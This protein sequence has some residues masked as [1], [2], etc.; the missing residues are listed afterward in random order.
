MRIDVRDILKES[1]LSKFV[2]AEIS[3]SDIGIEASAGECE[4]DERFFVFAELANIKGIIRAKGTVKSGYQTYCARCLK[5]VRRTV[6]KTF[7]DEY[8][9]LGALGAVTAEEAE[10]YEYSDKEIDL[11]PALR[12]A[13]L[14]EI[15]IRHLCRDDCLSLCPYCGKDLNEGA[16]GCEALAGDMRFAALGALLEGDGT[17]GGGFADAGD[18]DYNLDDA[19]CN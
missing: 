12:E 3:A 18:A 5:P 4:F 10:V 7:D 6:D 9:R 1:G 15:P 8:V 19:E 16:C 13:V 2:E 11:G 14:L 17:D